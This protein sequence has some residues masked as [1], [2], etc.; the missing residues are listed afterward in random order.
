MV[1]D[2]YFVGGEKTKNLTNQRMPKPFIENIL[3]LY[4]VKVD[5]YKKGNIETNSLDNS[6]NNKLKCLVIDLNSVPQ[7]YENGRS[8]TN[9]WR[10]NKEFYQKIIK[11]AKNFSQID[12]LIKSKNYEWLE[13][14]YFKE[15]L[16]DLNLQ[17]NIIILSDTK[18]WTT[19]KSAENCDF[20]IAIYSSLS[21]EI[22]A[23]GKPAI[24]FDWCG[25]PE[26]YFDF[27]KILAKN[28]QETLDKVNLIYKDYKKYNSEIDQDRNEIY[29]KAQPGKLNSE[30]N[31]IFLSI[32]D[33]KS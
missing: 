16:I 5:K 15:I 1:F 30:L 21:D 19:A 24:I 17:K 28:Y 33:N 20:A 9:N 29:F 11:L 10:L 25:N 2:Y 8:P 3:N 27:G 13:I 22:L 6:K 14:P 12:F 23:M 32:K 26:K 31:K 18:K 7:W 4:L